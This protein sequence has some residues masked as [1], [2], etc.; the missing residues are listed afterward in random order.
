MRWRPLSAERSRNLIRQGELHC[1][2][3]P[4]PNLYVVGYLNLESSHLVDRPRDAL[5]SLTANVIQLSGMTMRAVRWSSILVL[6]GLCPVSTAPAQ[7]DPAPTQEEIL[8]AARVYASGYIANLPSFVCTQ[9]VDQFEG[10]RK[11]R[12]WRKG[13]SLTS[14]LIWDQGRERRTLK[15]VNN[16]PVS[17]NTSWPSPLVSEGEFG[18]LLDNVLREASKATFSLRGWEKVGNRRVAVFAYR[19]DQQNSSMRLTFGSWDALIPFEGLLYTEPDS[20]TVWRITSNVNRIPTELK[21]KSISRA[22]DYGQVSIGDSQYV[23]PVHAT[24]VLDTGNG[25]LRNELQFDSYRKFSAE[26]RISF[27]SQNP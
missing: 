9:T 16:R 7:Q 26:S 4:R 27:S 21:T 24:V 19:V 14:Q 5:V 17:E 10:D 20:G 23:L 12:R 13:D 15:L 25:H 8:S 3:S 22:V 6:A 1:H 2:R 18:N 11:A